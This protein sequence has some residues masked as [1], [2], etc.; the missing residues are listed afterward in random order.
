MKNRILVWDLPTRIFHWSLALS[1]TIA[2]VT[3]ESE[4][5]RDIHV[6]AGYTLLALLGFRLIWGFAGSRYARFAEFVR[7]PQAILSYGKS[8]VA[9]RPEHHVGHNPVGAIAILLLILLGI[10]SGVSGWLLDIDGTGEWLEELHELI[11]N[12]ML[13]VVVM[14]IAGVLI[15]SKLHH[16]NLVLAMVTGKKRGDAADAI[17]KSRALIGIL[18]VVGLVGLWTWVGK[19]HAPGKADV[20]MMIKKADSPKRDDD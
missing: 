5:W 14:H 19:E 20:Q 15:S 18:L 8:L 12:L 4:G 3:A 6:L 2:F 9:G 13:A 17:P 7:G 10:G 1:F 11:S 16:E